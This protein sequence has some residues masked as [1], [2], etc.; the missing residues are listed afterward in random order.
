MLHNEH[1]WQGTSEEKIWRLE[2]PL[3]FRGS[4]KNHSSIFKS[5]QQMEEILDAISTAL[6]TEVLLVSVHCLDPQFYNCISLVME[7]KF[8]TTKWP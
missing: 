7:H 4:A 6:R 8:Q 1:N 2:Q 3:P 5:E